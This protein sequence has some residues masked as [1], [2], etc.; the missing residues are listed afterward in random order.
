MSEGF[1][2]KLGQ[3]YISTS[4][5]RTRKITSVDKESVRFV[6]IDCA[7]LNKKQEAVTSYTE[8]QRCLKD[9]IFKFV[10][11]GEVIKSTLF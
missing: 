6:C 4:D 9:D 5:G 7:T 2:I 10:K 8:F 11:E 3:E 1:E